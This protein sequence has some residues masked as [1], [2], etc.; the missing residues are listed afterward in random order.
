[1]NIAWRYSDK[2][3]YAKSAETFRKVADKY[4]NSEVAKEALLRAGD[5]FSKAGKHD[6]AIK[7]Y[8]EFAQKYP[9]DEQVSKALLDI[10]W[11]YRAIYLETGDENAK[12]QK[13]AILQEIAKR[14]PDT[15]MAYFALGLYYED[16]GQYNL[17]IEQYKKCAEKNGTQKDVALFGIATCYYDITMIKEAHEYY[18][19]LVE[20]C[21]DSP[22]VP[23]ATFFR[24]QT[25]AELGDYKNAIKDYQEVKEKYP[26][27]YYA[28]IACAFIATAYEHLYD[29]QSAIKEYQEFSDVFKKAEKLP[30]HLR[31]LSSMR[32]V[33]QL[34]IGSCYLNLGEYD[35][36]EAIWRNIKNDCPELKWVGIVAD[37][38]ADSLERIRK[39]YGGN[40]PKPSLSKY[41]PP[42][43][44]RT[45]VAGIITPRNVGLTRGL[46]GRHIIVYGTQGTEEDREAGLFVAQS[47]Q[48]MELKS[49]RMKV[50]IKADVEVTEKD[51]KN[52]PLILVGTPG[53]NKLIED[54]KEELPIRVE[55]EEIVVGNRRY[56]GSDVGVFFLAP[57]PLNLESYVVVIEGLTPTALRNA[58]NI[59]HDSDANPLLIQTDYLVYDSNSGGPEKPVLE[60]GFFIKETI[61]NWHPL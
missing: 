18:A 2:K 19:K 1:M 58:V 57:N 48:R 15:E 10:A 17:A 39:A 22:L 41:T 12:K 7:A 27:S 28:P 21:P 23:N 51:I 50:D 40:L 38:V 42:E 26:E 9:D 16:N 4:P 45:P 34:R 47:L 46:E 36:A 43:H 29:Y 56:K 25:S 13:E 37:R 20:E 5:M 53:S 60:E 59:H 31:H 14:F 11:R 54:L 3:D 35:K 33:V 49:S 32:G 61:E 8:Q 6:D 52:R 30:P 55:K 44:R 24:G